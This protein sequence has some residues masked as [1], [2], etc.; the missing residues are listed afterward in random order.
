MCA[1]TFSQKFVVSSCDSLLFTP[2]ARH[3]AASASLETHTKII[4]ALHEIVV[5]HVSIASSYLSRRCFVE[6]VDSLHDI[7]D[8][9][10]EKPPSTTTYSRRLP[11]L[12]RH[13]SPAFAGSPPEQPRRLSARAT[14]AAATT[15]ASST[16]PG[17]PLLQQPRPQSHHPLRNS[18]F[19]ILPDLS[20]Y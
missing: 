6:T 7:V 17:L 15:P 11:V 9:F 19:P 8:E 16:A 2:A 10:V 13:T 5:D 14:F 4:E 18:S 3:V 1:T 12:H 20:N